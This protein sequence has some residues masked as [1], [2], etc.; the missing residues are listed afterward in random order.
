MGKETER[1]ESERKTEKG[2]GGGE[3]VRIKNEKQR[4][5]IGED[6][7]EKWRCMTKRKEKKGTRREARETKRRQKRKH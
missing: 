6:T 1:E 4:R 5:K 7:K 3:K 2:R